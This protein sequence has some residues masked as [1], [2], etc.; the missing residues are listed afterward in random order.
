MAVAATPRYR[1]GP[2]R[3][4]TAWMYPTNAKMPNQGASATSA[5]ARSVRPAKWAPSSL[6]SERASSGTSRG[7]ASQAAVTTTSA[8]TAGRF[9]AVIPSGRSSVIS[10]QTASR[11]GGRAR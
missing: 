2:C 3:C 6:R 5:A 11:T 4:V 7:S 9:D 1:H 10:V 8:S